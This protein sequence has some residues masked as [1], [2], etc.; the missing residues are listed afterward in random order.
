MA[1]PVEPERLR[2]EFPEL[3]DEDLAAY[4]AV[5]RRILEAAPKDRARLTREVLEGGREAREKAA[6]G[7]RLSGEEGLRMR[8]ISAVD[9]IQRSTVK[10]PS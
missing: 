8:Y 2:K 10:R 4:V 5:T 3:S 9:K 6:R 7:A 1:L